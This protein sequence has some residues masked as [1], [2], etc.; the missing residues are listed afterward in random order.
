MSALPGDF[1][2]TLP[3][4]D[5]DLSLREWDYAHEE[6][7]AVGV[8]MPTHILD[9][10]MDSPTLEPIFKE[11]EISG[12]PI[13]V[14]A[15]AP[16]YPC[17]PPG[18]ADCGVLPALYLMVEIA[19]ALLR[20]ITGGVFERHPAVR[21]MCSHLGGP[22]ASLVGRLDRPGLLTHS[23]GSPL[24]QLPTEQL[25]RVFYDTSSATAATAAAAIANWGAQQLVLGT[26][27]PFS[28]PD[29]IRR[30]LSSI[31]SVGLSGPQMLGI[32][33]GN[34]DERLFGHNPVRA[35]LQ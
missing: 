11:L 25:R 6:L 28:P 2:A 32:L 35:P 3:L 16:P 12:I 19:D 26:D 33:Q 29:E 10:G 14:H 5:P 13:F 27:F 20:M 4:V 15:G 18:A 8:I 23:D 34:A 22:L 7:K 30:M 1:W 24:A 17:T 31:A 21:M 9:K